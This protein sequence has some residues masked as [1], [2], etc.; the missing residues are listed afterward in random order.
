MFI[1]FWYPAEWSDQVTDAPVRVR[2][3]GQD[4]VVF[5]DS[6][7]TAHCLSNTCIHRGGSLAG[8][9][10][11]GDCVQCPYHGWEFDG[12]GVCRRIP[13]LGPAARVPA[14][15]RVDAYP[16]QER[17]GIVFAFLGDLPEDE[18]PPLM[19]IPE[20]G[21]PGW[22]VTTQ[23]RR[24]GDEYR[25]QVENA[26]DPAH[27]EFV[28]PTHGFSGERDDYRVPELQVEEDEWTSGFMTQYFAPPLKDEKMKSASGRSEDATIEAGS[29]HH[30]PSTICTKIHPTAEVCIHQQAFKVPVDELG[31]RTFLVQTRNF[32]LEPEHDARFLE[33]NDV[34]AGQDADVLAALEPR[35]TPETNHHEFLL[36]ADAAV[37]RYREK[38]ALWE[39][40]GWRIDTATVE[41]NRKRAAYAIPSP[42][43][44]SRPSGWV[45]DPVPL[46]AG[47]AA[48]AARTATGN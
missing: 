21:Q 28:H 6:A 25:R 46:L 4:F 3:L 39:S 36:P 38:L 12:D 41:R 37:V 2:M 29:I 42:A 16:T 14:R 40:R 18:R 32:L 44:R 19:D 34:V 48:T 9:K 33:R 11:A 26:L 5:R 17:Y 1:N 24:S 45:L 30:G 27:N 7:G 43:R 15:A 10:V 20:Y 47:D 35:L 23:D 22:R 8:G 31:T 13:S